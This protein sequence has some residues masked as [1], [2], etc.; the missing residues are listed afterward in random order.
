VLL[1]SDEKLLS[2]L[3]GNSTSL[4]DPVFSLL[5]L[6]RIDRLL[7]DTAKVVLADSSEFPNTGNP[8]ESDGIQP[9][10]S[11]SIDPVE[12]ET[13]VEARVDPMTPDR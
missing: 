4:A 13:I 7:S 9:D 5:L 8:R 6:L 10:V 2:S 1:A 11:T 12:L 3:T